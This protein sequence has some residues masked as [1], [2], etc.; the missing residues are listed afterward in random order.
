MTYKKNDFPN[1]IFLVCFFLFLNVNNSSFPMINVN[2]LNTFFTASFQ[3]KVITKLKKYLQHLLMYVFKPN[4]S[5]FYASKG[6]YRNIS[7][8][9][10][11]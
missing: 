7:N 4:E 1:K 11:Y 10:F 6:I 5:A 9:G 3:F 2:I 8:F